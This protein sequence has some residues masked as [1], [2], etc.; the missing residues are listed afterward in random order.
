MPPAIRKSDLDSL[1]LPHDAKT[2]P[3]LQAALEQI[4]LRLREKLTLMPQMRACGVLHLN[5]GRLAWL[6][7]DVMFYGASVPKICIL[8]AYFEAHPEAAASLDPNVERELR[9]MIKRSSN[10][11][12]AK[13]SQQVGLETIQRLQTEK[14]SFYDAAHGGGLWC[15]KHYGIAEPV[16]RDPLE[17]HSHAVTVRQCLRF[18]LLLEQGRLVSPAVSARMKSIFAAPR[19]AFHDDN[20]VHGLRGRGVTMFR[21]NGLWENWHLDTARVEHGEDVYLI[22]AVADHPRGGEYLAG[23][24]TGVDEAI[25]GRD[26]SRQRFLHDTVQRVP[27]LEDLTVK[28]PP[29]NDC[30]VYESEVIESRIL[31][32]EVLPSWNVEVGKDEGFFVEIRVG[33]DYDGTWSPYLYVGDWGSFPAPEAK[34]ITWSIGRVKVDFFSSDELFQRV[35]IRFSFYSKTE[36]RVVPIRRFALCLSDTTGIPRAP[37]DRRSGG[38]IPASDF[39]LNDW[40][41]RLEVPGRSQR[42]EDK[43]ISSRICSPTS[44][45][46]VVEYRK[47]RVPTA[48]MAATIYDTSHDIYGNWPR[49]IQGAF[50]YGVPG[51][52]D[53]FADWHRVEKHIANG[54]PLI[55][56]IRS[57]KGDIEA[58]P[59]AYPGGHLLVLTGFDGADGVHVNDPAANSAAE[60]PRV[61]RRHELE[62]VW[63][64][65]GGTAYVLL[66]PP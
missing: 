62:K 44:V 42:V 41:R 21:K 34:T 63:M 8:L 56:S 46:M 15:G 22:A 51:Y 5:T 38:D 65:R 1:A 16:L 24:A 52:L 2:D 18:Y 66:A 30:L 53:R 20:F 19:L 50:T 37:E 11:L 6:R 7:P 47:R 60:A 13:Y 26:P 64:G 35:Q 61:Y 3:T 32:N 55:I 59:F 23:L 4:D 57:G 33:R 39:S 54:Q 29:E 10:E 45:A 31:F 48:V 28:V 25:C 40:Q 36:L 49:A 17:N 43:A 14:Y 58:A 27:S 9:L 12:A